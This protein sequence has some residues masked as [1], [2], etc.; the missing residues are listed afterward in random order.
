[1]FLTG[2]KLSAPSTL[3]S[4]AGQTDRHL[5]KLTVFYIKSE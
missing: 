4:F 3:Y 2:N 1:M 5:W